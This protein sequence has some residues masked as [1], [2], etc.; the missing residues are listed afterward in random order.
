M[1]TARP[2]P[3]ENVGLYVDYEAFAFE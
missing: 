2:G 3:K 1:Q